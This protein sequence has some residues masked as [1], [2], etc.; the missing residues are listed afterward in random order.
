MKMLFISVF[1]SFQLCAQVYNEEDFPSE[2]G[3][4]TH[5]PDLI[6]ASEEEEGLGGEF[7]QHDEGT[8]AQGR[9]ED[10][11]GLGDFYSG[12]LE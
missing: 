11:Q 6:E 10:D 9:R 8:Y 3:Q 7:E 2:L 1:F 12:D 4:E 5:I